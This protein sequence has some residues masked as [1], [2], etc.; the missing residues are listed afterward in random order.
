MYLNPKYLNGDIYKFLLEELKG[1]IKKECT[2]EYGYILDIYRII[3]VIDGFNIS[4]INCDVICD[5]EFEAEI[6]KPKV[7]DEYEGKVC[8]ILPKVGVLID[9]QECLKIL[10][11]SNSLSDYT[12][13]STNN[14]YIHNKQKEKHIVIGNV[15]HVRL[16]GVKYTE[17][18]FCCFGDFIE[19]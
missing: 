16:R 17:H 6:L 2:N 5:V 3:R 18:K 11:K 8:V 4:P 10:V 19:I 13:N 9:V 12:Y 1:K 7:N 15:I 14:S